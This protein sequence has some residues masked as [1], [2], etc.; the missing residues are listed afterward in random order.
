MN[1][2]L[3]VPILLLLSGCINSSSLFPVAIVCTLLHSENTSFKVWYL[4]DVAALA[5][6]LR[7]VLSPG[8]SSESARATRSSAGYVV[9]QKCPVFAARDQTKHL[10]MVVA[11]GAQ[12]HLVCPAHK[13]LLRKVTKLTTAEEI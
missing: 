12:M 5:A 9:R 7:D 10:F 11:S 4:Q 13:H 1:F 8:G 6:I 2:P 3:L